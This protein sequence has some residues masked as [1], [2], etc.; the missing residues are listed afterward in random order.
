MDSI[1]VNEKLEQTLDKIGVVRFVGR[2]NSGV[3]PSEAGYKVLEHFV[4]RDSERPWISK[5][6]HALL[7]RDEPY[8]T[9]SG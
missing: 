5:I 8:R 7:W 9:K 4:S 1:E 2:I 3:I 6:A